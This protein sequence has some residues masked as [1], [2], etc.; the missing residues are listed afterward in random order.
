MSSLSIVLVRFALCRSTTGLSPD[1]VMVSCRDPTG[2]S[3]LTLAT[4]S[5]G[6]STASRLT[7][8]N[9]VRVNVTVY[10][11]G[12]RSTIRYCPFTSEIEER[13]FSMRT[14]LD[15]STSTPGS[16]APDESLTRPA[17]ADCAKAA[18]GTRT[19]AEP[20]TA[21]IKRVRT[22]DRF[23]C[24]T[25]PVVTAT[26]ARGT[27]VVDVDPSRQRDDRNDVRAEGMTSG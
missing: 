20:I 23:V 14:S 26:P 25:P 22:D 6:T 11:P 1:T 24:M 19:N 13:T 21:A 18:V 17:I 3:A 9:P 4:K 10:T 27:G 16:T 8:L 5:V 12:R 7:V 15:A 2:R